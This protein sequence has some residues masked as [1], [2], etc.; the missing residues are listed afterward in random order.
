MYLQDYASMFR[1]SLIVLQPID[2]RLKECE[3]I[4]RECTDLFFRQDDDDFI[5]RQRPV[6]SFSLSQEGREKIIDFVIV[7]ERDFFRHRNGTTCTE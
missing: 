1:T 4:I 5:L 6:R 2:E 3:S 7:D